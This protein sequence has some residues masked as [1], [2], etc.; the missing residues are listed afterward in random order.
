MQKYKRAGLNEVN[1]AIKN[2][3]NGKFTEL[4]NERMYRNRK[5]D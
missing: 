4:G 1:K 5:R 3:E 2:V